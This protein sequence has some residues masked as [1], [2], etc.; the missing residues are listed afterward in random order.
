MKG[1][2]GDKGDEGIK[3]TIDLSIKSELVGTSVILPELEEALPD[4]AD[5]LEETRDAVL[6]A[7]LEL[8]GRNQTRQAQAIV[9]IQL[10]SLA[11]SVTFDSVS[12][13]TTFKAEVD[14][15]GA[16]VCH[17]A[18]CQSISGSPFRCCPSRRC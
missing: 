6:S 5:A 13:G 9:R 7:G 11:S 2:K 17:C 15:D 14:P 18:D 10:K 1:D 16:Y 8:L 4:Y 12:V 3:R